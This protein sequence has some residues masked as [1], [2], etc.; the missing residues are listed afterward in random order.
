[1]SKIIIATRK[2]PLALAQSGL[3]SAYLA[4][5]MPGHEFDIRG[6]SERLRRLTQCRKRLRQPGRVAIP[7][8]HVGVAAQDGLYQSFDVARDCHQPQRR[9]YT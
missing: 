7:D 8:H 1:M 3:V 2:S 4:A 9:E 5:R 6:Q